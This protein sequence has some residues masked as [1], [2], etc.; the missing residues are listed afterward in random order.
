MSIVEDP[1]SVTY[2]TGIFRSNKEWSSKKLPKLSAIGI[3]ERSD[4][5][6]KKFWHDYEIRDNIAREGWVKTEVLF[7]IARADSHLWYALKSKHNYGNVGNN[8]RGDTVS[9]KSREEGIKAIVLYALNGTYL[10]HKQSIWSLSPWWWWSKPY[11]ATSKENWNIN[12]LNCLSL[13]YN[14]RVNEDFIFRL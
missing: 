7:C 9:Y 3:A 2:N 6:L 13:M 5:F 12:V 10:K 4:E 1:L 11:Y 14:K 8:D